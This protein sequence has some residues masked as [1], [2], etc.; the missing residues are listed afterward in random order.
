MTYIIFRKIPITEEILS[1]SLSIN[2]IAVAIGLSKSIKLFTSFQKHSLRAFFFKIRCFSIISCKLLLIAND[3]IACLFICTLSKQE[4]IEP[5]FDSTSSFKEILL[6]FCVSLNKAKN[7]CDCLMFFY[8]IIITSVKNIFN[9][10]NFL[11]SLNNKFNEWAKHL[12]LKKLVVLFSCFKI[13]HIA[14]IFAAL[15]VTSSKTFCGLI[16]SITEFISLAV[17]SPVCDSLPVDK[18]LYNKGDGVVTIK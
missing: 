18:I 11:K 15:S 3:W 6:F 14:F 10:G 9:V 8:I 13:F 7:T 4:T 2:I 12:Y 5:H 16:F 1:L 17:Y